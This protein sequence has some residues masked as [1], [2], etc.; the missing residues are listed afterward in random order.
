M[1]VLF[2]VMLIG[3]RHNVPTTPHVFLTLGYVFIACILVLAILF[4]VG[5]YN[6][7]AV[8]LVAFLVI[9]SWLLL[10]LRNVGGTA[11]TPGE[12]TP[13]SPRAAIGTPQ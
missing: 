8:E 6:L 2:I 12:P 9:F 13:K 5:Y 11:A 7:T 4:A 10:F 1:A 3:L